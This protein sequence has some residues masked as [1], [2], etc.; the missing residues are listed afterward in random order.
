MFEWT[1]FQ[2]R[3][4]TTLLS[5]HVRQDRPPAAKPMPAH[6]RTSASMFCSQAKSPRAFN[7]FRLAVIIHQAQIPCTTGV[8]C[9]AGWYYYWVDWQV[10]AGSYCTCLLCG[11]ERIGRGFVC[12]FFV[13]DFG[14][15]F[16]VSVFGFESWKGFQF[17]C[18]VYTG[19][20]RHS[21]CVWMMPLSWIK[22]IFQVK[23]HIT[24]VIA[25]NCLQI[26]QKV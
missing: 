24:Q 15:V 11:F 3:Q 8:E 9:V 2:F 5:P 7:S 6:P 22:I 23:I 26:L 19:T 16:L 10:I 20:A 4:S 1:L 12:S 25:S 17:S 21:L 14:F 13:F 18:W